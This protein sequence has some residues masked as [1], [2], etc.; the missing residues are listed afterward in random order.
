ML[1][2]HGPQV[3]YQGVSQSIELGLWTSATKGHHGIT[4]TT[5]SFFVSSSFL[6]LPF[7]LQCCHRHLNV[8][9][10]YLEPSTGL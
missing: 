8:L 2:V 7:C 1:L 9:S 3:E 5:F 4:T 10:R 6:F